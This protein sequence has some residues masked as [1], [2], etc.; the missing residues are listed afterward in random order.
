M[1][2]KTIQQDDEDFIFT[3]GLVMVPRAVIQFT[4]NCPDRY[5]R[6]IKKCYDNGWFKVVANMRDPEY[7]WELL[8]K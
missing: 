1:T 3:D 7:T 2:Y 5:L 4:N 6:I 8:Q